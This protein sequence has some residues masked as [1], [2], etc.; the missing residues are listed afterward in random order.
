M[1]N[2]TPQQLLAQI[3]AIQHM[4]KGK[5]STYVPSGRSADVTAYYKL[6]IWENGRNLTRHV[7]PEELPF[8][9]EA[10]EGYARFQKLTEEYSG[11]IIQRTRAEATATVK[12]KIQ[13]Y[14][15]HCPP[16]SRQRSK[17]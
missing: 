4:E 8:L 1:T 7:R 10:L 12:K 11:L 6:Q 5:L 15:R 17:A 14:S 3:A 16:K 13:P 9:K 2:N